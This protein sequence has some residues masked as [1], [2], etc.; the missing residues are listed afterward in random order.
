MPFVTIG[1]KEYNARNEL[2]ALNAYMFWTKT[3]CTTMTPIEALKTI[4]RKLCMIMLSSHGV[5]VLYCYKMLMV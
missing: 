2:S 4:P 1:S 3:D 5:K